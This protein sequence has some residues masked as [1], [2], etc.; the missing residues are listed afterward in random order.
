MAQPS[1]GSNDVYTSAVDEEVVRE[2]PTYP[3]AYEYEYENGPAPAPAPARAHAYA[4]TNTAA[5]T[6]PGQAQRQL[7]T[8]RTTQVKRNWVQ[9]R[10]CNGVM[11]EKTRTGIRPTSNS[12]PIRTVQRNP[13]T[14]NAAFSRELSSAG[15]GPESQAMQIYSTRQV[16][17]TMNGAGEIQSQ[18][19]ASTEQLGQDSLHTSNSGVKLKL[20]FNLDVEV[21]L[22]AKIHGDLTLALL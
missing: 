19:E 15:A 3:Y 2:L 7:E 14:R 6:G 16:S 10:K 8:T 5:A 11:T 22:K 21:E 18:H 12:S 17:T 4:R 20:D 13:T 1:H 9:D